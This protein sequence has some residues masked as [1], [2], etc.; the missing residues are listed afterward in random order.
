MHI[1]LY[2]RYLF[3]QDVN[4]NVVKVIN[5]NSQTQELPAT[6]VSLKLKDKLSN[7]RETLRNNSEVGINNKSSCLKF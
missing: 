1:Y 3:N 4:L 5:Y 6:S 2:L 7:V